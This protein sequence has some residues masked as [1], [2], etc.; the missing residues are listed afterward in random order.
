MLRFWGEA[1]FTAKRILVLLLDI[2][3]IASA[4]VMS[5]LLRFDFYIPAAEWHLLLSGLGVILIIKPLIFIT[6]G[7]YRN[8]WRYASLQDAIEIL[9]VVSISTVVSAF[10]LIFVKAPYG[11][12]RSIYILDW[13]LLFSM[14][15]ASRLI[16]RVYRETH[17]VPRT[18]KGRK[19]LIIGAGEAGSLLLKEIRKQEDSAYNVVGFVDDDKEKQG[20]RLGGVPVLGRIARLKAIVRQKQVEEVI[21]AIP[22]GSSELMRSVVGCCE[23]ARVRFKTLPGITAGA[24]PGRRRGGTR[25]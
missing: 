19:T 4:F 18:S 1:M 9:K 25:R 13:F 24:P 5:F 17:I 23:K 15:A 10:V 11:L 3:L 2:A 7:M 21:F 20:L 16:W 6:S 22:S 14:V 8:I 12:P